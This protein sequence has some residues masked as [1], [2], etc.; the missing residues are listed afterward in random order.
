MATRAPKVDNSHAA[1]LA[2][3][4]EGSTDKS[5]VTMDDLKAFT[6]LG[7]M[8]ALSL[9][10]DL[11]EA[12]KIKTSG[13]GENM[14]GWVPLFTPAPDALPK[15]TEVTLS[16]GSKGTVIADEVINTPRRKRRTKAEMEAARAEEHAKVAY[17]VAR[18]EETFALSMGATPEEAATARKNTEAELNK[19]ESTETVTE[20][21]KDAQKDVSEALETFYAEALRERNEASNEREGYRVPEEVTSLPERPYGVNENTWDMAYNAFSVSERDT[22]SARL[23]WIDRALTQHNAALEAAFTEALDAS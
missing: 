1:V 9:M 12:G 19:E 21:E 16:D 6:Q 4:F 8:D 18:D 5:P 11:E 17:A 22:L 13:R 10:V 7:T 3:V 14:V 23:F 15:G 2:G 20:P